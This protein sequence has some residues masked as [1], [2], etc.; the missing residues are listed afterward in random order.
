MKK[1][2]GLEKPIR[3]TI[4]WTDPEF[5]N[6]E[7]IDEELRRVFDICHGCRRCFN[8]C[9]SFPKLFELVDES[10]TGE[11]DS[12]DSKDFEGV[13]DACTLCDMCFLTKCPYV[14]PHE[15]NLDFPH[16]MLRYRVAEFAKGKVGGIRQAMANTDRN[17][18]VAGKIAGIVNWANDQSN[19]FTRGVMQSTC[20]IQKD[21]RIPKFARETFVEQCEIPEPNKLAPNFGKMAVLYATCFGNYNE[22]KINTAA[23][24]VLTHNGVEVQVSYAGCCGMPNLEQ[25]NVTQVAKQAKQVAAAL[26]HYIDQ[27]NTIISTIP[28]C[29]FMMKS[30]WP[31]LLPNDEEIKKLSMAVQ[32]ISEYIVSLSKDKGLAAGLKPLGQDVTVH[33]AC[34]ARAQNIGQKGAEL[35]KLI[36]DTKVNVIERCSG[37]GGI[38]GMMKENFDTSLKVGRPVAKRAVDAQNQLVLS[39]C[40]LAGEH[41]LQGINELEKNTSSKVTRST[42]HP[43]EIFA[44]AYGL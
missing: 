30:E 29:T 17:A 43:I 11:L 42:A 7:K 5:V 33:I 32:D 19:S 6:A 27:G 22:P 16:L 26:S 41:I 31:L 4:N 13:V 34:H 36:P 23:M 8:L 25:G 40:P 2:G 18:K 28:S 14:P 21:A 35:L 24:K 44:Q 3:H 1:E 20:G 12:V 38:W 10:K 15:F 37:H 9:D 39:E